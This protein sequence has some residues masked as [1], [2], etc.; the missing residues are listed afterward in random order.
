M[1]STMLIMCNCHN[2]IHFF[3]LM[4]NYSILVITLIGLFLFLNVNAQNNDSVYKTMNLD[5]VTVKGV[6]PQIKT[7][8]GLT[9]IRVK[10]TIL[11]KMDDLFSMLAKTPGLHQQDKSIVVNGLGE[12]VFVINGREVK[13]PSILK[14][15][16]AD[17][18]SKIEI[19]KAPDGEYADTERPVVKITTEKSLNDNLYLAVNGTFTQQQRF[20]A[21]YG[22]TARTNI[23]KYFTEA[24]YSSGPQ[25]SLL[26][27]T[28]FRKIYHDDY[29][30]TAT[31][32]RR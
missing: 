17:N 19:D 10:G 27:E 12:P 7:K 30:F 20:S 25:N 28:Y 11:E 22:I 2:S 16:K 8:N 31:Q 4:K 21:Y 9:T 26:I 23:K 6:I 3:N 15:Y 1:K 29:T 13:D 18:I 5:E 24:T 32:E 14:T